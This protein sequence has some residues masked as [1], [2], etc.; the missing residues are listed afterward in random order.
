MISSQEAV[1]HVAVSHVAVS[2]VEPATEAAATDADTYD[3]SAGFSRWRDGW[4]L[5]KKNWPM[6][7][8]VWGGKAGFET[9]K[10]LVLNLLH[11][12]RYG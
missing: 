9:M 3:C 12:P 1:S 4:S 10:D 5:A 8:A 6:D 7:L 2:H 11:L